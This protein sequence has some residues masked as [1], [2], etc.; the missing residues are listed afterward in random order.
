MIDIGYT[1][2]ARLIDRMEEDEIIGGAVEGPHHREVL[3][4]GKAAP[5]ADED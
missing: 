2:A 3:D 1:R 4:Y 5:P